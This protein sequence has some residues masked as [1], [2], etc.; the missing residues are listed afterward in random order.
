MTPDLTSYSNI[1]TGL[2]VEINPNNV[3]YV[4][5][6]DYN[7]TITIDGNNYQG[8]GTL[9]GITSTSS[10]LKSTAEGITVTV[11]GLPTTNI[12]GILSGD[13]KGA[14][15]KVLRVFFDATTGT[16][17]SIAGNPAGRFFGFINNYSIDEEYDV[18]S[19]TSVNTI[20]FSCASIAEFLETKI[21][22][23]RTNPT[24][25]KAFNATDVSMDRV[26]NLMGTS[27]VFGKQG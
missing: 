2:F 11:T 10:E 26:P 27:V 13:Y 8:L 24:S 23:R 9:V 7:Q 12:T 16:V 21:S 22:G 25:F 20:A 6:S 15:I 14:L 3:D 5:F 17:L 4:R 19:R 1:R 18:S